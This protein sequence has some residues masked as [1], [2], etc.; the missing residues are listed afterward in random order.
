MIQRYTPHYN[1]DLLTLAK[2]QKRTMRWD[3][4]IYNNICYSRIFNYSS[5]Y[6]QNEKK[7][8]SYPASWILFKFSTSVNLSVCPI[9]YACN[10]LCT[11]SEKCY[12]YI[13]QK[14]VSCSKPEL[15]QSKKWKCSRVMKLY[16]SRCDSFFIILT[17]ILDFAVR[18]LSVNEKKRK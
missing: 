16:L 11:A 17:L 10:V 4:Y 5:P 8:L 14:F 6:K 9:V 7:H 18:V 13:L 12:L 1:N 15:Y 2:Q 3:P